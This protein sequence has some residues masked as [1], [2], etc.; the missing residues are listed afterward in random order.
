[1]VRTIIEEIPIETACLEYFAN[2]RLIVPCTEL[3]D[4]IVTAVEKPLT[5]GQLKKIENRNTR[6]DA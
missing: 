3:V 6:K 4:E 2:R 5:F 1:M